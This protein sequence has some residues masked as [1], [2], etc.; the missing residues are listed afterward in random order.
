VDLNSFEINRVSRIIKNLYDKRIHQRIEELGFHD[1][2]WDPELQ[3]S[4][5]QEAWVLYDHSDVKFGEE[6]QVLNYIFEK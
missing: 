6:E 4:R 5:H 2:D 1:W 3:C